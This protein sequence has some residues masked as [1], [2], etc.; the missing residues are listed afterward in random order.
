MQTIQIVMDAKLL[1]AADNAAKRRKISRSELIR[2][3]LKEHLARERAAVLDERDRRG[4]EALPQQI[5]E[6]AVWEGNAAWP[7]D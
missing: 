3:A 7:E 2:L 5:E 6:Y 4:Y 1:K